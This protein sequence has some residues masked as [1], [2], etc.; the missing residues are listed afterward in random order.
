MT[1]LW[2]C[3]NL[4]QTRK[5][6]GESIFCRDHTGLCIVQAINPTSSRTSGEAPPLPFNHP[7]SIWVPGLHTG[8]LHACHPWDR[9]LWARA[10]S[11]SAQL[12]GFCADRN[13]CRV[14]G[15]EAWRA[16]PTKRETS[17]SLWE[18]HQSEEHL[19]YMFKRGKNQTHKKIPIP[20]FIIPS[21]KKTHCLK[22]LA[23]QFWKG[24]C[25]NAQ[26]FC[27]PL[28]MKKQENPCAGHRNSFSPERFSANTLPVCIST[29]VDQ[30][31]VFLPLPPCLFLS[32]WIKLIIRWNHG[33][34]HILNWGR[35]NNNL[36]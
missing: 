17:W 6:G 32:F 27:M 28:A 10:R 35:G 8:A 34:D 4:H 7:Q 31:S 30:R 1:V 3:N 9:K 13:R 33:D 26:V 25:Y 36:D 29:E 20:P 18:F 24:H 2:S 12:S 21:P 23:P 19:M 5:V 15:G 16:T 14:G 22:H 11:V